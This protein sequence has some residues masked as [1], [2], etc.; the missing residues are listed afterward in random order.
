MDHTYIVHHKPT[1]TTKGVFTSLK[2]AEDWIESDLLFFA[3]DHTS[4]TSKASARK[5]YTIQ[6][7]DSDH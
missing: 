4:E 2:D 1:N 3:E 7:I 6:R 5:D